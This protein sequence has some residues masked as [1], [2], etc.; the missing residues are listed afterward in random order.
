MIGC[1]PMTNAKIDEIYLYAVHARNSEQKTIPV[2]IFP[3]RMTQ[4]NMK[5]Y[6]TMYRNQPEM[7][8]FWRNLKRGHDKFAESGEALRV[9]VTQS[10]DYGFGP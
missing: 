8:A 1:V 7:L 6:E 10:G 3:F 9:S 5:K 2:Y 4:E